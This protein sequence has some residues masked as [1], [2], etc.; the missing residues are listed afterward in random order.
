MTEVK[1][2]EAEAIFMELKKARM[3][4]D[5]CKFILGRRVFVCVFVCVCVCCILKELW[6]NFKGPGEVSITPH[7]SSMNADTHTHTPPPPPPPPSLSLPLSSLPPS[8]PPSL[9]LSLY[10]REQ[11]LRL[12]AIPG[13]LH[14]ERCSGKGVGGA[15]SGG[16]RGPQRIPATLHHIK[17]RVSVQFV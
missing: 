12:C 11:Q 17:T 5:S 8:L 6:P 14:S 4:Y 13:W 10:Y 3:P 9:P 7:S 16:E 1:R 15:V 2:R